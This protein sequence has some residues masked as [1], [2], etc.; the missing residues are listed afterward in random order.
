MLFKNLKKVSFNEKEN[1]VKIMV[2]W[3]LAY[4]MARKKY[5]EFIA[6]DR[7]R[8]KHRIEKLAVVLNPILRCEHRKN[9]YS[10]RFE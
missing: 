4:E 8:F 3:K 5:W 9:I 2:T 6:L 10:E 1:K 7:I